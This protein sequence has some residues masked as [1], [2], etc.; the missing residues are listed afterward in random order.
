MLDWVTI[1]IELWFF[2]LWLGLWFKLDPLDFVVF[3]VFFLVLVLETNYG[4]NF[5]DVLFGEKK[6]IHVSLLKFVLFV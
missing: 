6:L 3:N 5:S 4:D 2:L 1:F